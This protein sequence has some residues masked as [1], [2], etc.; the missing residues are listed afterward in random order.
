MNKAALT[1]ALLAAVPLSACIP[2][3]VV[4]GGGSD[5]FK[6]PPEVFRWQKRGQYGN[7]DYEQRK[8]DMIE[9]GVHRRYWDK[10]PVGAL[11][12]GNRPGETN[13]QWL[14]RRKKFWQ[15]MEDK[16]YV[17]LGLI[18]CGPVKENRGICK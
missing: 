10:P 18:E 8:E 5:D 13:E 7:T 1:L 11:L 2:R 9:C 4:G 6:M 3:T 17:Q 14:A 15:C 16:D 12:G